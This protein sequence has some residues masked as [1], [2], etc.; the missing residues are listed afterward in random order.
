MINFREYVHLAQ[1]FINEE[2][3]I[4][5][6]ILYLQNVLDNTHDYIGVPD[7]KSVMRELRDLMRLYTNKLNETGYTAVEIAYML[8]LPESSVRKYISMI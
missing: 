8:C 4:W 1:P 6:R 2:E 7:R 3:A 5:E